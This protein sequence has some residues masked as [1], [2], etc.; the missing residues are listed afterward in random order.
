[1]ENQS[2]KVSPEEVEK[3]LSPEG[4]VDVIINDK[5]KDFEQEIDKEENL[6]KENDKDEN[7]NSKVETKQEV[8]VETEEDKTSEE[9]K[10][11]KKVKKEKRSKLKDENI[12]LKEENKKLNEK[13]LKAYAEMENSKKRL[14]QQ[15]VLDRKYSSQSLI[16]NLID[17]ID[18]LKKVCAYEAGTE[19][20]KNFLMGF[21]MIS[22]QLS[23]ILETEG[24]KEI[25]AK[26]KKFDPNLHHA[27]QK[28]H[29]DGVE[30]DTIIEVQ[31]SGYMY[32]DRVLRPAMVKVS[33]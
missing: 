30:P 20:M 1:M 12:K 26:G 31:Q 21:K 28:E 3:T 10:E 8:E 7:E 14:N 25:E 5:E 23:N 33:E 6:E 17:P 2:K 27:V 32:K 24:L 9:E 4:D 19:E 22:D 11:T 18:M 16:T 29:V 15:Y 13:Y